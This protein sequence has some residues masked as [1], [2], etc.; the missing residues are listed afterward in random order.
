MTEYARACACVVQR[1]LVYPVCGYRDYNVAF[2]TLRDVCI[3]YRKDIF[4]PLRDW[5]LWKFLYLCCQVISNFAHPLLLFLDTEQGVVLQRNQN[6]VAPKRSP[7][8]KRHLH[9]LLTYSL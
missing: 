3:Y 6:G 9:T 4:L 5:D 8:T 7:E 2:V 1:R